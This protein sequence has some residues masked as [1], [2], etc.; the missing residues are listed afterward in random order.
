MV[1]KLKG[2]E[3]AQLDM[4]D[5][6]PQSDPRNKKERTINAHYLEVEVEERFEK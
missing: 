4:Y 5:R 6:F 2:L 3:T 1:Q